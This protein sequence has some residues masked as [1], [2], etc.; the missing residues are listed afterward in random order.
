MPTERLKWWD[1]DAA[2]A[3]STST[4]SC[5]KPCPDATLVSMEL[6]SEKERFPAVP[7]VSLLCPI[8]LEQGPVQ[9]RMAASYWSRSSESSRKEQEAGPRL[10][11]M[12]RARPARHPAV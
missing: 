4:T 6:L 11:T 12:T 8:L 2:R 3:A 9:P 7:A 5:E 1:L 10:A